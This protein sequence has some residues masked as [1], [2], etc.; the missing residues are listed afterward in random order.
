MLADNTRQNV[1]SLISA[2]WVMPATDDHAILTD[3]T[4]V[5]DQGRILAV[6]PTSQAEAHYRAGHTVSLP[7]HALIPGLVNAHGHAGMTL[8]RGIADD[9]PLQ[10]WLQDHIWPLEG[11]WVSEEF[12]YHGT[13]LAIAEMLR[14][15]TTC[16]ADMYFF[17]E[18]VAKA[19]VQATIRCQ[20]AA[21]VIDF[22]TAWGQGPDEYISKTIKLHDEYRNSQLVK[23][24]FGPHAPYTVSDAPI[25]RISTLAEELDI[26]IHMHVHETAKEVDDAVA[27][28]GQRP[29]SRLHALGLLGPRLLAVHATQLADEEITLLA[30]TG[31]SVVHCPHSN[32]KLASGFCPVHRLQRAG[33]NVALGTD[34]AASNN[35]LDMF[36]EMQTA[37]MLGKAVAADATALPAYSALQMATINGAR[38]MGMDRDIGSL[39]A[40]KLADITA[41]RLDALNTQPVYNPVS[42]LVYSTQS[43]QVTHV[44]I[45]GKAVVEDSRLTTINTASLQQQ[46]AQWQRRLQETRT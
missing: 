31:A 33:V 29:I 32:L 30:E 3:H 14:G 5:V 18:V 23:V 4:L 10:T 6:L 22:P 8:L 17:P 46:T 13:Q 34:G 16:F 39:E 36:A 24:A 11:K 1:D 45:G 27:A 44:W 20:L 41:V 21:P 26:P 28:T 40:G 37:A 25:S 15:G 9:L 43:S 7:E 42:H 38:A 2:R 35:D 12:V 19:A